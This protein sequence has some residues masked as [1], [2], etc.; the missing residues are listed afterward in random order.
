MKSDRAPLKT[1]RM[2]WIKASERLPSE[3]KVCFRWMMDE[4]HYAYSSGI[5][6]NNLQNVK[7]N[8]EWLDESANGGKEDGW[9]DVRDRLPDIG[10]EYY[11]CWDLEDGGELASTLMEWYAKEKKWLDVINGGMDVTHLVKYWRKKIP[12]PNSEQNDKM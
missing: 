3:K 8:F 4:G 1:I 2:K 7:P 9:I 11:V 6:F 12:P 5:I 10:D